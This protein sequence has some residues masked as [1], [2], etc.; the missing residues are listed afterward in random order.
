MGRGWSQS[1]SPY[2]ITW[3]S[4]GTPNSG[5]RGCLSLFILLLGPSS[6]VWV[7]SSSFNTRGCAYSYY[8]FDMP[9]LINICGR[10]VSEGK[11][12]DLGER[13]IGGGTRRR[14]RKGNFNILHERRI[15]R[16]TF[17]T[18]QEL[19]YLD[20]FIN[21]SLYLTIHAI[22]YLK[23][24]TYISYGTWTDWKHLSWEDNQRSKGKC[25]FK[26]LYWLI[27]CQ[28]DTS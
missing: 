11:W 20:G 16:K 23:D 6:S 5:S 19:Q 7:S 3:G 4:W 8:K 18:F 27:L 14:G 26:W 21:T 25:S 24:N 12:V 10:L 22:K 28:L 1:H 9:R 17:A 15:K 2:S 13:G